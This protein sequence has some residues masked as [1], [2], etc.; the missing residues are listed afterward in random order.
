MYP[1]SWKKSNFPL[2]W[3][4]ICYEAF[5]WWTA[6]ALSFLNTWRIKLEKFYIQSI[7]YKFIYLSYTSVL[8]RI[9]FLKCNK[10]SIY[11]HYDVPLLFW[12]VALSFI[13]RIVLMLRFFLFSL[14]KSRFRSWLFCAN[15]R[16]NHTKGTKRIVFVSTLHKGY[17]YKVE[18]R[19]LSL[20]RVLCGAKCDRENYCATVFIKRLLFSGLDLSTR[21]SVLLI[22]E[23]YYSKTSFNGGSYITFTRASCII[24]V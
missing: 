2:K 4:N 21:F 10:F 18:S 8:T 1:I 14:C 20:W 5:D 11:D 19:F 24:I 6:C 22:S 16:E 23:S 17:G 7:H 13:A 3:I 12:I 15:F 9:K